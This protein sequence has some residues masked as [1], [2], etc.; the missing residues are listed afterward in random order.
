MWRMISGVILFLIA[1]T[2]GGLACGRVT[3]ELDT[4]SN[5]VEDLKYMQNVMKYERSGILELTS[6]LR[7]S[8]K[9]FEFWN[10]MECGLK[11]NI[12]VMMSW[13]NASKLLTGLSKKEL[14]TLDTFFTDFGKGGTETE[15][16]RF[17][18]MLEGICEL[19]HRKK[20]EY[21][22]R[23]KLIRTISSLAGL[24]MAVLVL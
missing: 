16:N 13:R 15:L 20:S 19:E 21:E 12:G 9:L 8:G 3:N 24:A 14:D 18:F 17:D 5:M 1:S 23:L 11:G 6:K 22:N 7:E 4:L 2:I 10:E